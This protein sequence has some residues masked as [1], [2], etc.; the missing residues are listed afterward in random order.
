MKMHK[1]LEC[2]SDW[3]RREWPLGRK[4]EQRSGLGE[5]KRGEGMLDARFCDGAKN[6]KSQS[7]HVK[8]WKRVKETCNVYARWITQSAARAPSQ[9]R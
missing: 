8:I 5:T 2:V 6:S 1:F 7:A 3:T 4:G 9:Q